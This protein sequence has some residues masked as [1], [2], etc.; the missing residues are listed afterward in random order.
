MQ[1]LE[2]LLNFNITLMQ[3][4]HKNKINP[5][6][7]MIFSSAFTALFMFLFISIGLYINTS[8]SY[9]QPHFSNDFF[10]Y[11]FLVLI[12]SYLSFKLSLQGKRYGILEAIVNFF[13]IRKSIPLKIRKSF[14]WSH[15][16]NHSDLNNFQ[17]FKD[18][19]ISQ[20]ITFNDF[21]NPAT[22]KLFI[23]I[24][25]NKDVSQK[26]F[27][28]FIE[29]IY[30]DICKYNHESTYF[31]K[32]SIFLDI[33]KQNSEHSIKFSNWLK[34]NFPIIIA[35]EHTFL[36]SSSKLFLKIINI[37][38]YFLLFLY[39]RFF[40]GILW[41]FSTL[42]QFIFSEHVF[43]S[44]LQITLVTGVIYS[45][46]SFYFLRHV[47]DWREYWQ[48]NG[49]Y[50]LVLLSQPSYYKTIPY[51]LPDEKYNISEKYS[52]IIQI[53]KHIPITSLYKDKR[54]MLF[55]DSQYHMYHLLLLLNKN[56][57]IQY[58]S[59]EKIKKN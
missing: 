7:P 31:D 11:S 16:W 15:F 38:P 42:N 47:E 25:E 22:Q 40:I 17:K 48:K 53:V 59:I 8:I 54:N 57:L 2:N 28:Q 55:D 3:E 32:S 1:K 26:L 56:Y 44:F 23:E 19:I 5:T 43:I 33:T 50:F 34:Y 6:H 20:K 18:Y 21:K 52:Q 29:N 49:F 24:I 13:Y 36:I 39:I 4:L 58:N 35:N 46:I 37:I 51:S 30:F 9:S 10:L 12:F 27:E 14:R 45:G 41:D